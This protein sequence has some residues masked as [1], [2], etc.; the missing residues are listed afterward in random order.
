MEKNYNIQII[1]I[2]I[3][4]SRNAMKVKPF[5]EGKKWPYI[6]LLD[7][8]GDSRRTLG[9]QNPPYTVI[10]DKDGNIVYKHLGY[11][12]GDEFELENK[13]KELKK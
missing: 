6:V 3:D 8:N 2:S 12:E 9:Y 11:T 13:I 10:V 4:D 1:A 7:V 5:I